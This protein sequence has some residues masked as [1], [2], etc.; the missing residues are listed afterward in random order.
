M[1]NFD[2]AYDFWATKG[3][4]VATDNVIVVR[5]HEHI[6]DAGLFGSEDIAGAAPASEAAAVSVAAAGQ[7]TMVG[8]G[9]PDGGFVGASFHA[10]AVLG[11]S[12]SGVD[13]SG[14]SLQ[15]IHLPDTNSKADWDLRASTFGL[16]NKF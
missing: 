16:N 4:I 10:N 9:A 1:Y 13:T 7:W 6:L 8:G 11:L 12:K 15:R 2:A 14:L 3:G 5:F